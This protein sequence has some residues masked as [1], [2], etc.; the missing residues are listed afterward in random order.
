MA[1]PIKLTEIDLIFIIRKPDGT[2]DLR[3]QVYTKDHLKFNTP[4]VGEKTSVTYTPSGAA[5]QFY[6]GTVLSVH[7]TFVHSEEGGEYQY[8]VEIEIQT[9]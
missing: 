4:R 8:G 7:H 2:T 3:F 5:Q 1:D 9:G 6:T